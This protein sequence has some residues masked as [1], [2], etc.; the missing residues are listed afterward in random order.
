MVANPGIK[1]E[2]EG[3]IVPMQNKELPPTLS[4][5]TRKLPSSRMNGSAVRNARLRRWRYL[6]GLAAAN[7]VGAVAEA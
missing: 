3:G 7:V 1:C 2:L 6:G 4:A 5:A